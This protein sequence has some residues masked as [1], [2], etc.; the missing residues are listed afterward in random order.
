LKE[1]DAKLKE[2]NALEAKYESALKSYVDKQKELV[3]LLGADPAKF[4]PI[5]LAAELI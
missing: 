1:G 3:S 5:M 2:F 4:I